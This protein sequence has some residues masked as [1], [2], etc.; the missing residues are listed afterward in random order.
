[1]LGWRLVCPIGPANQYIILLI[2]GFQIDLSC[3]LAM[4]LDI[5]SLVINVQIFASF[6]FLEC[7]TLNSNT[8][9]AL[10]QLEKLQK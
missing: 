3:W 5:Y 10:Q 9:I 6:I 7:Q 4:L 1:M 8:L 2:D